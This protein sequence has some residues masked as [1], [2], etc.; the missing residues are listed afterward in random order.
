MT[1]SEQFVMVEHRRGEQAGAERPLRRFSVDEYHW[2][3]EHG[4]FSWTP[5]GAWPRPHFQ[6]A[7]LIFRR[8]FPEQGPIDLWPTLLL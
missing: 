2:L 3:I 4:F 8:F 6:S 1:V 5:R 7:G